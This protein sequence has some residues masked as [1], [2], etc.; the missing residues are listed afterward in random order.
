MTYRLAGWKGGPRYGQL[1]F[2]ADQGDTKLFR[3]KPTIGNVVLR[4]HEILWSEPLPP[5]FVAYT[6]WDKRQQP[7]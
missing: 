6:C 2:E 1:T 7:W 4:N 3:G 5:G